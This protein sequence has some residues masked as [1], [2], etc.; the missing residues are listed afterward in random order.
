[1]LTFIFSA[2]SLSRSV[3]CAPD[4]NDRPSE[5]TTLYLTFKLPSVHVPVY[6]SE[7]TRTKW[8]YAIAIFQF[9]FF[10]IPE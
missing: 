6:F 10:V 9:G 1:M 5:Q 7:L 3:H 4:E 8:P 2:A